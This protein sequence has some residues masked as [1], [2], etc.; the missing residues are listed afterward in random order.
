MKNE[1]ISIYEHKKVFL[2]SSLHTNIWTDRSFILEMFEH[3]IRVNDIFLTQKCWISF[4]APQRHFDRLFIQ[5]LREVLEITI[6][7]PM[8]L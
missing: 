3:W 5:P 8:G 1:N 6:K 2:R 4:M 7:P